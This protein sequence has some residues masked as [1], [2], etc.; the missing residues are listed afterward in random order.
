MKRVNRPIERVAAI[1]LGSILIII[2]SSRKIVTIAPSPPPLQLQSNLQ[3]IN[4]IDLAKILD[5]Q[6]KI[7]GGGKRW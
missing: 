4:G 7:L 1:D 2:C 3:T 5:G 6:T